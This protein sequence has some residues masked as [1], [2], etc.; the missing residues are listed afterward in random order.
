MQHYWR[1]FLE[2]INKIIDF[3]KP[4]WLLWFLQKIIRIKMSFRS[5]VF[6][7][8]FWTELSFWSEPFSHISKKKWCYK[9]CEKRK[10]EMLIVEFCAYFCFFFFKT[11]DNDDFFFSKYLAILYYSLISN[12]CEFMF[13]CPLRVQFIS[14]E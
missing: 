2:T 4:T 12:A 5:E 13:C 14:I 3:T 6:L 8:F 1:I 9:T 10:S 11:D 7:F